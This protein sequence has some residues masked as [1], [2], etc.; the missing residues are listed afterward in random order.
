MKNVLVV[1]LFFLFTPQLGLSQVSINSGNSL[2]HPAAMLDVQSNSKG[3]LLPRMTTQGMTMISSPAIGLVVYN[4]DIKSL[5][6]YDGASWKKV[7]SPAFTETDPVFQS[8]PAS[9]IT[10]VDIS[11]WNNTYTSRLTGASGVLP[12]TLRIS[13]NQIDGFIRVAGPLTSGYLTS[14]NWNSFNNKQNALSF[15]NVTSPDMVIHGGTGAVIGI[16]MNLTV[17][18]AN[19]ISSDITISG[20]TGALTGSETKLSVKKG[21]LTESNSSVLIISGGTS[22][23]TGTGTTLQMKQAGASQSGYVSSGDWNSFNS[24]QGAVSPGN[25]TSVDITISGG[26]GAVFSSGVSMTIPKGNLTSSDFSVSG[27]NGAILGGG[28]SL[29]ANKGILTATDSPVFT[30]LN[31]SGT[32]NLS[33]TDIQGKLAGNAQPGFLSSAHF[34]FFANKV[35]SKWVSNNSGYSKIYYNTGSVGIGTSNPDPSSLLEVK[36]TTAGFLPPR[37]TKAQRD[38]LTGH[39]T[40]LMIFCTDCPAAERLQIFT[41]S[42][43]NPLK[44]NP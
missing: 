20:G 25:L 43:W 22:A 44:C 12:L 8:F 17:N 13:D 40:G 7:H 41:G 37:M 19:L 1:L 35:S 38:A 4:T 31:N 9:G 26:N 6:W 23:V 18:K 3:L 2:P 27:G 33:G 42:S 39:E 11:N 5:Y 28:V 15:G 16:G 30:I 21:N 29:A 36:S 32:L 24:K 14:A 10:G 34:A